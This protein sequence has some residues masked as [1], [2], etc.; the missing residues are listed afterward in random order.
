MRGD[1]V[2]LSTVIFR[3]GQ[4]RPKKSEI[5]KILV[6]SQARRLALFRMELA[7]TQVIA[8]DSGDEFRAV[9][10]GGQ[11]VRRISG[12]GVITVYKIDTWRFANAGEDRVGSLDR[13]MV[14]AH[15][16]DLQPGLGLESDDIAP[17]KSQAVMFTVFKTAIEQQLQAKTDTHRR[18]TGSNGLDKSLVETRFSELGYGVSKRTDTRQN[19]VAVF[20]QPV[21]VRN[22]VG[23]M[24]YGLNGFL[25][26]AQVAHFIVD[27]AGTS[28]RHGV[29]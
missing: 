1:P 25:N 13:Q 28:G 4:A 7:G 6:D 16:R 29:F 5:H 22:N 19:D 17:D 21:R 15:V 23:L 11:N 14:P 9:V 3:S 26:A 10:A 20:G 24:A 12:L 18:A 27:N 2:R 8:T